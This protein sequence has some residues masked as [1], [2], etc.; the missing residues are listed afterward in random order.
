MLRFRGAPL[1]EIG[2]LPYT[3]HQIGDDQWQIVIQNCP[4]YPTGYTFAPVY[5]GYG[6][7]LDALEQWPDD[8][9]VQRAALAGDDTGAAEMIRWDD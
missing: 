9:V 2:G 7:A 6:E 8:D 4:R 5:G 1:R 3:V